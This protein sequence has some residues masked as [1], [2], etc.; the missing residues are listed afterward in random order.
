MFLLFCRIFKEFGLNVLDDALVVC[1]GKNTPEC[2]KIRE[3]YL[4]K[5]EKDQEHFLF[6]Y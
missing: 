6:R 5:Y 3:R 4:R 2:I 1:G